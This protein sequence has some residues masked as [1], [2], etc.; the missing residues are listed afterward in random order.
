MATAAHVTARTQPRARA[1][2]RAAV[3]SRLQTLACGAAFGVLLGLSIA[4]VG[5][6]RFTQSSAGSSSSSS[7]SSSQQQARALI[8]G[9]EGAAASPP[10]QQQK[11][12]TL[13]KDVVW[14]AHDP[15]AGQIATDLWLRRDLTVY[16]L[17]SAAPR[18]SEHFFRKLLPGLL[19]H[20]RYENN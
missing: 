8:R 7:S 18:D 3:A 9:G 4:L 2:V 5:A 12:G 14:A 19:E 20:P 15:V 11:A 16:V 17:P 1:A 13:L 10:Q 6:R